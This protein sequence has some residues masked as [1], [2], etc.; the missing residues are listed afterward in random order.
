MKYNHTHYCEDRLEYELPFR[1]FLYACIVVLLEMTSGTNNY[2][3]QS[4]E[5][6][7][8]VFH[9]ITHFF[10]LGVHEKLF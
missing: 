2:E 3:F 10:K 8:M 5:K 9:L 4:N 6:W 7:S 1:D